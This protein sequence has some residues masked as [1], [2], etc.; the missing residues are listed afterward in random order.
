MKAKS[1]FLAVALL[2]LSFGSARAQ[3][4]SFR[5]G[6]SFP[7]GTFADAKADYSAGNLQWGLQGTNNKGG[8]GIGFLAGLQMKFNIN[9]IKGLGV[10]VS[11][12]GIFNSLN[13]DITEYY[14]DEI[15]ATETSTL[16][17]TVKLPKYINIP[18]MAGLNY[19]HG[20]NANMGVFVEAALGANVRIITDYVR[21]RETTTTE[22]IRTDAYDV[23]TTFAFRV[24]AGVEFNSKYTLGVDYFSLGT[25]KATGVTH[26][27]TNGVES[28]TTPKFKYGKITPSI[29]T[30][31]FG[32]NF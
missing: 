12:D 3:H 7:M 32:I 25:A 27:E 15:D 31:R 26:S 28:S 24:G 30:L 17:I 9:S 10:I 16:D 1:I 22:I 29:L 6:G 2:A 13:G 23:A 4:F 20:I 5:L 18:I 14:D 21:I 11:A 19:T 8:A